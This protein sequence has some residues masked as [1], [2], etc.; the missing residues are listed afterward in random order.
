[1]LHAFA[2]IAFV[3]ADLVTDDMQMA[4]Q[5][6]AV[7]SVTSLVLGLVLERRLLAL[8]FALGCVGTTTAVLTAYF[9][10]PDI[11][12]IKMTVFHGLVGAILL[13]LA[14]A[15]L[16]PITPFVGKTMLTDEG[17]R[18]LMIVLGALS[19]AS[20]S[21]PGDLAY[22]AGKDLGL[23]PLPRFAAHPPRRPLDKD[24]LA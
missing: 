6:L 5:A 24:R 8:P 7:G 9:H 15:R 3:G 20:D 11:L 22:A 1:M 17:W 2:L 10:N 23:L 14:A 18:R 12:K 19:V 21:Q 4:V 16:D 13:G